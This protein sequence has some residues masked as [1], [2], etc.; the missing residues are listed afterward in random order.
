MSDR[1]RYMK[2]NKFKLGLHVHFWQNKDMPRALKEKI[3]KE[4][5]DWGKENGVVFKELIP[6][7]TRVD[8]DLLDICKSYNLKLKDSTKFTHDFEL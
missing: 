3:I 4:A 2:N 5:I 7:W 8:N 1:L 6:G